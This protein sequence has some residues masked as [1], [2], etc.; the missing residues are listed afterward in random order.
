V[1]TEKGTNGGAMECAVRHT[2]P[3]GLAE[4]GRTSN[5]RPEPSVGSL[6]RVMGRKLRR[7]R[8]RRDGRAQADSEGHGTALPSLFGVGAVSRTQPGA[9]RVQP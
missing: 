8:I 1:K 6:H 9:S 4:G 7:R 3:A 5:F 2:R